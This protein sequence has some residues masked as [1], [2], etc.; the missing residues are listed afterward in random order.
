MFDALLTLIAFVLL[1]A[2]VAGLGVMLEQA[3]E[4]TMID[5]KDDE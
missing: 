2:M 5:W 4:R 1:W 3:F